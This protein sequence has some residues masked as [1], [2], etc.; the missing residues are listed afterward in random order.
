[1]SKKLDKLKEINSQLSN[2]LI[3]LETQIFV[4]NIDNYKEKMILEKKLK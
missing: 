1:M 2:I 4:E 3:E